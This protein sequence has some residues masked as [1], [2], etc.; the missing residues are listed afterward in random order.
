[1]NR[2]EKAAVAEIPSLEADFDAGI[3]DGLKAKR[4]W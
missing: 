2:E 3:S 4:Q 1:M